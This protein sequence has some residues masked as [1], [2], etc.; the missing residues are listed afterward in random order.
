MSN[1]IKGRRKGREKSVNWREADTGCDEGFAKC[2][3]SEVAGGHF[4]T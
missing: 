1:E 4:L 3:G 2:L